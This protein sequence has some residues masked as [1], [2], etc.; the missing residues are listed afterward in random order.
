M[1]NEWLLAIA[2]FLAIL[3]LAFAFNYQ[4]HHPHLKRQICSRLARLPRSRLPYARFWK[5]S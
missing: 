2:G 4:P 1:S 5:A 3:W